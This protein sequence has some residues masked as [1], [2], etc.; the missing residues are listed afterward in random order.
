MVLKGCF[1][2]A[3]DAVCGKKIGGAQLVIGGA[4]G[5]IGGARAPPKRYKIPPVEGAQKHKQEKNNK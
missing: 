4:L 1:R 5:T 2:L 3:Q